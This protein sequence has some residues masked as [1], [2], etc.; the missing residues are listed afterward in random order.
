MKR[1]ELEEKVLK[2]EAE[3]IIKEQEFIVL[4]D[5]LRQLTL[6]VDSLENK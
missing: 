5:E 4:Q 2:L 3:K 1:L 6:R